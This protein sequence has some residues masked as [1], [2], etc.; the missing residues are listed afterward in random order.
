MRAGLL[1]CKVRV[2]AA[3]DVRD[4]Y[5][6]SEPEWN[7]IEES[8]RRASIWPLTLRDQ[9][10]LTHEGT[11]LQQEITHQIG[12]RWFAGLTSAH[13]LEGVAPDWCKGVTYEL[14]AVSNVAGRSRKW[15]ILAREIVE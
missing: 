12:M 14:A 2:L 13:R 8:P 6:A 4:D 11:G 7:P 5:G 1:R 9:E 15:E 10:R 3:T